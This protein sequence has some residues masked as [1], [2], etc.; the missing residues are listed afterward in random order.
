MTR[1]LWASCH[2]YGSVRHSIAISDIHLSEVERSNGL[3]M[4]YRQERYSPAKP[5][6]EL[7]DQILAKVPEGD[8]LVLVL[9]GDIFDF[10]APVAQKDGESVF[11]DQPRDATHAVP[12]IEA[13]LRDHPLFVNALAK[14]LAGGHEVC[15]VSG[16]HDVQLTL[17]EV[18]ARVRDRVLA[19]VRAIAPDAPEAADRLIF[20]AWFYFSPDGILFE[21]GNQYDSYCM[22]RYPMAPFAKDSSEIQ[23][24]MGSLATR[25]LVS[26]MGYFNPHVDSSFMLTAFGYL[27]HWAKYYLFSR[28]SLAF[29]WAVGAFRTVI[30]LFR[31][32]DRRDRARARANAL[33]A[34]RESGIALRHV[35]RHARL[36]A[37]PAE[38][39]MGKV[40]RE[41][42][43][44]RVLIGA[45]AVA[46]MSLW[47]IF[48]KGALMFG[49]ALAPLAIAGYELAVPRGTLDQTWRRVNRYAR[50]VG[51][52]HRARAV[53]FGHTHHAEASWENGVFYGNTGSWSAAYHDLECTRPIDLARPVI[54]L[55]SGKN[56][57]PELSGGMLLFKDGAF[58][59]PAP[60]PEAL[61]LEPP[62][63]VKL[64]PS[65]G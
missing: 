13:I 21:H 61:E 12:M 31:R 25:N 50:R 23:P 16:N 62:V 59:E 38:D 45:A 26:R 51:A 41:L 17:P 48:A 36:F 63:S 4:R 44:D 58:S 43:V 18:R 11:H 2:L 29:A 27:R 55:T 57:R 37:T 34:A 30:E 15:F 54:W 9:N 53:V 19:A 35:V 65:P 6:A 10:D 40:V 14:V 33:A 1:F 60:P 24:T 32:R 64:Q 20:R 42:W 47:I 56:D 22:F 7:V 28:R 39:E 49:A 5:I 46:F 52:V 8:R 3:W